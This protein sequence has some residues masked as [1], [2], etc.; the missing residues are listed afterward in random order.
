GGVSESDIN[1]ARASNALIVAFNVRPDAKSRKLAQSYGIKILSGNVIYE[2]IENAKKSVLDMLE[3]ER[4]EK[5][6]GMAG[7]LKVFSISKVGNIAGCRVSEGVIRADARARLVRD[8]AIVYE[9][10]IDSLRHFK[11]HAEE[12]RSGEECGIAIRRFN[13]IKA[14]DVIEAVQITEM[15]PTL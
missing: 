9:G 1:L 14:G 13:D 3:A 2:I 5:I 10:E 8:G 4:E 6:I 15:P 11:E 7:V 12:V